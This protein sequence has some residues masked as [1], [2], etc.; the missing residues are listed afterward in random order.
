MLSIMLTLFLVEDCASVLL[1]S[2]YNVSWPQDAAG[3]A[4]DHHLHPL[5][6]HHGSCQYLWIVN[7]SPF[8][9]FSPVW[10]P[11]K[12]A[13]QL[14]EGNFTTLSR[15][16]PNLYVTSAW[17]PRRISFGGSRRE[18]CVHFRLRSASANWLFRTFQGNSVQLSSFKPI[19]EASR[20]MAAHLKLGWHLYVFN[21]TSKL[22]SLQGTQTAASPFSIKYSLSTSSSAK[23]SDWAA[24]RQRVSVKSLQRCSTPW[25]VGG[26]L[27]WEYHGNTMEYPQIIH[28]NHS[29]R[30]APISGNP[31]VKIHRI[32][33]LFPCGQ[34]AFSWKMTWSSTNLSTEAFKSNS[35]HFVCFLKVYHGL[36]IPW[37]FKPATKP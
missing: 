8:T 32:S 20:V 22:E 35:C 26:F 25:R 14:F 24:R 12:S 6:K 9:S 7:K 19:N 4:N 34:A 30:G 21:L 1:V 13:N 5:V 3:V 36:S 28:W 2:Q 18:D 11:I 29:C 10:Q 27:K 16:V 17:L 15:N 23:N 37:T 33:G 31:G